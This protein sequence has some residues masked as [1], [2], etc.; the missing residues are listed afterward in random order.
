MGS[1]EQFT[2]LNLFVLNYPQYSF[3]VIG[4]NLIEEEITFLFY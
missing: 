2:L 1:K 3:K 4:L